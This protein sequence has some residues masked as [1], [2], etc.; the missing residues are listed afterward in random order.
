MRKKRVRNRTSKAISRR[1]TK[2]ILAKCWGEPPKR[3]HNNSSRSRRVISSGPKKTPSRLRKPPLSRAT[4]RVGREQA[5]HFHDH[6][7]KPVLRREPVN[8]CTLSPR[9][10]LCPGHGVYRLRDL[11]A[12]ISACCRR[13]DQRFF[14]RQRDG[15]R[16]A[17][18]AEHRRYRR[19]QERDHRREVREG[20]DQ[21]SRQA[22]R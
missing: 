5:A 15:D 8:A 19:G 10:Q 4:L 6:R 21:Y 14:R 20:S 13:H 9:P 18:S 22:V 2:K 17:S 3:R 1:C 7:V 12:E 16:Q 11:R